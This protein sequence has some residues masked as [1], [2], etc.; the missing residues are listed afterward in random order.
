MRFGNTTYRVP[1][2]VGEK[3]PVEVI[4]GTRFINRYFNEIECWSQTIRLHRGST[5]PILSRRHAR[6]PHESLNGKPNDSNDMH[7]SPRNDKRTNDA[8]FNQAHTIRM[9]RTVAI[10]PMSQVAIPF[11]AKASG[12]VS[13]ETKLPVQTRYYV[14]TANG[15]RE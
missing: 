7:A 8:T 11:V 1:F 9:A 12:L 10:L 13:I 5:I 15:M 4:V 6:R 2:I 14:R 3:L